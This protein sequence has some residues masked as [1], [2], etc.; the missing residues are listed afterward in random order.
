MSKA[1][2]REFWIEHKKFIDE[3]VYEAFTDKS[4][5][6]NKEL[7]PIHVREV[8]SEQPQVVGEFCEIDAHE[9]FNILDKDNEFM[10][11]EFSFKEGAKWQAKQQR[12]I[13]EL[14]PTG[15]MDN[16]FVKALIEA[17][18]FY[19][20]D[21]KYKD[22][23]EPMKSLGWTPAKIAQ[24]ALKPFAKAEGDGCMKLPPWE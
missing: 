24:D 15:L 9:Q 22:T 10:C 4:L 23:P 11:D 14:T 21:S 16:S 5:C 6:S 7:V 13:A 12:S 2:Q 18:K 17:L 8:T 19:A 1:K 20:D 3:W